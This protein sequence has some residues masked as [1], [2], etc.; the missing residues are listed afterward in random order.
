MHSDYDKLAEVLLQRPLDLG[1][2]KLSTR[3]TEQDIAYMQQMATERFDTV[4]STLKQMPRQMLFVIRCECRVNSFW[5][6]FA[7]IFFF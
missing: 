3:L 5:L 4:L 2:N 7:H 1:V 6:T